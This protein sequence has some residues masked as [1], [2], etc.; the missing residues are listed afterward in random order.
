[1]DVSRISHQ[2]PDHESCLEHLEK[3][4]WGDSPHCP[5]C[6]S[7][8]VTRK[9]DGDRLGRWNCYECK[10]SFNV[11]AK[12]I[13]QKTKIPLQKWFLAIVIILN[14]K[15]KPLSSSQLAHILDLNQKSAWFMKS[16]LQKEVNNPDSFVYFI[17]K[18]E[19]LCKDGKP[20]KLNWN[21]EDLPKCRHDLK[22]LPVTRTLTHKGKTA[23]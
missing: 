17:F 9:A 12:T 10:S 7:N 13:F 16:R 19:E 5:R 11:L 22:N 21:S 4:R 2:F 8:K 3:M 1:M 23:A 18:T 6:K 20:R 15:E 14:A